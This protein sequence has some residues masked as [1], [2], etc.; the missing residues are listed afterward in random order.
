MFFCAARREL[1]VR[2]FCIMSWSMPFI[3]M[4]MNMPLMNCR[5]KNCVL[6]GSQQNICPMGLWIMVSMQEDVRFIFIDTL[7][8]MQPVA[9]S[10]QSVCKASVRTM[11]SMPPFRV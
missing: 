5:R 4:V 6:D 9:S 10:I 2:F 11:F 3:T 1:Q 8:T 7:Q